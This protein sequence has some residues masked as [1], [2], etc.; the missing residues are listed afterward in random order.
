MRLERPPRY[1]SSVS[2]GD[3]ELSGSRC[4]TRAFCSSGDSTAAFHALLLARLEQI[5]LEQH[6]FRLITSFI[7]AN[8]LRS[9]RNPYLFLCPLGQKIP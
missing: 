3:L 8:K 6:G 7:L 1:I 4:A 5:D 2:A 9:A